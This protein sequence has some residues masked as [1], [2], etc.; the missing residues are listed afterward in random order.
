MLRATHRLNMVV[1]SVKFFRILT[2]NNKV[3][4]Q[5]RFCWK[6]M[7]WPWPLRKRP[8][9]CALHIVSIRWSFLWNIFE[10][11]LQITKLWAGHNFA[12]RSCC[13]LDLQ[14]RDPNVARNVVSIWWSFL[15]NIFEIRL[16]ITKLWAGHYFSARSCCDLYLQG[17]DPNMRVTCR[18]N[19]VIFFMK[20]FRNPTSNNKVIGRTRF[21]CKVLDL[22]GSD[23]NVA[24]V[25]SSQYGDH[26]CEIFS[27]SDF[28]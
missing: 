3:M 25:M 28:K 5:T 6:V 19:M 11:Q 2:S 20:Y 9:C 8:K 26:F 22:Q 14:G 4:D 27:K 10:I 24:R 17:S 15:W 13:D 23:P 7:L 12:A 1:I 18:L 16:Q 21:L